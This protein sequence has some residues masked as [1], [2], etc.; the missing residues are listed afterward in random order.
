[1]LRIALLILSSVI[2]TSCQ[3]KQ[4]EDRQELPYYNAPNFTPIFIEKEEEVKRI[5][6]HKIDHF[7]FINQ[8]EDRISKTDLIGKIHVANFMFTSCGSIC[9]N[10]TSNLKLVSRQFKNDNTVKLLSYT[11][12][13]WIDDP[14]KLKEY[15]QTYE[16]ENQNWHFLTGKKSKIYAL[17]RKSY[18]AEEELGFT[19]DSADFLH[20]EH[21]LLVDPSL[22]IRGIYNGTLALE[23]EQLIDDITTLKQAF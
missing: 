9:P 12:T 15:K 21:F 8:N 10:M 22:R 6:T 3:D 16:I 19:K 1:M 4:N 17:A 18:F 13:P 14:Q 7:S 5:I 23:M 20:T 2:L 11:V